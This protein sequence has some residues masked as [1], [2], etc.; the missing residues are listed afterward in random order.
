VAA[1]ASCRILSVTVRVPGV[2]DDLPNLAHDLQHVAEI[3][4][5]PDV[6][7]AASLERFYT[8]SAA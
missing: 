7:D 8:A 1:A 2:F 5:A 4:G 3:A 6:R